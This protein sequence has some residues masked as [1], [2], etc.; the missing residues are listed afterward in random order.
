MALKRFLKHLFLPDWVVRRAF[1]KS[2]LHAIEDAITA[3]EKL[4]GG[5]LRFVVEAGWDFHLL[6]HRVSARQR[7]VDLFA[8]LRVWDTEHN[9]GV[10][11]YVQLV[12]RRV[13][14]VA[15]RGISAR[16]AQEEWN[17]VCRRLEQAYRRG[18]YE[19]G[20]LAVLTDVT[21]LLQRHFPAGTTNPNE[22]P[23]RPLVL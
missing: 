23:D 10:L 4:H 18:E 21:A 19:S 16:V 6:W 5:E 3:S 9:S 7:A 14:I 13:E 8:R 22:L 1:S 12:E 11:I 17:S 20:T 2:S 15:D